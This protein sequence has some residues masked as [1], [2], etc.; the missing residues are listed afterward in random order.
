[1]TLI[2]IKYY[3]NAYWQILRL[4]EIE[5]RLPLGL[6]FSRADI[7]KEKDEWIFGLEFNSVIV[8]SCQY[9]VEGDKAKMRQVATKKKFQGKGLGRELYLLTE[10]KMIENGI[11][12]IYCH[13]RISA[14]PFYQK[15]NFEIASEEF[16]EVGIPHIIMRK[17]IL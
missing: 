2:P 8:A 16:L 11:K 17:K 3:S 15:F 12:E 14:A 1:M 6:R 13:S 9:I 5:L 4:R 7:E 10:K